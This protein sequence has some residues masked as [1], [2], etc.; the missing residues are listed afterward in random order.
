MA[1]SD[2]KPF[3]SIITPCLNRAEFVREAIESV[4]N[5]DY[6]NFEHIVIDG[7]STDGTL[8]I[9]HEYPHL[10]LVSEP[11]QGLYDAIN[12]GIELARGEI[13]GLLNTDDY[14]SK[15]IF[16]KVAESFSRHPGADAVLGGARV[17][18]KENGAGRTISLYPP[19]PES[20]ML[21]KITVGVPIFN[22]WFFRKTLFK[23]VGKFDSQYKMAA[24]REFLL[25]FFLSGGTFVQV[26]ELLYHYRYHSDSLT[27]SGGFAR[28]YELRSEYQRV[29][30]FYLQKTNTMPNVREALIKWHTQSTVVMAFLALGELKF[31][32]AVKHGV[33]GLKRDSVGWIFSFL[34][35]GMKG[36]LRLLH[37]RN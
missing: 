27:L 34:G 22:A 18:S 6:K 12:K 13:I 33:Q 29:V 32:T 15:D 17:F 26:Q 8:E 5:Q 37:L 24:D 31:S 35:M 30:S 11:D 20:K 1:H 14:Y 3:I 25:R 36:M 2:N 19:F 28:E 10:R 9:L 16:G 21:G 7:G 23:K 4:L